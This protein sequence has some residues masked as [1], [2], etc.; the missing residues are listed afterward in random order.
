MGTAG[1]VFDETGRLLASGGAQ[2]F[3]VPRPPEP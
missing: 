3:C 1:R 2:L